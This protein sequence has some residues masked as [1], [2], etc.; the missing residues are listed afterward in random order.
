MTRVG[1]LGAVQQHHP[2]VPTPDFSKSF[3]DQDQKDS[4][5]CNKEEEKGIIE[6]RIQGCR[7]RVRRG[8]QEGEDSKQKAELA[9]DSHKCGQS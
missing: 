9:M 5:C 6:G 4:V 2:E 7:M 1:G 3:Q 8:T